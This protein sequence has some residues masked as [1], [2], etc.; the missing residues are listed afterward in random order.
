MEMTFAMIKPNA[1]RAG[2]TAKV[3]E[4]YESARLAICGMKLK[5]MSLEDVQGFYAEHVEKPFFAELAEFM[6]SGPTVLLALGGEDAVAK[7]RFLNGA[8][9]PEKADPGTIRHDL[10]RSI[11]ENVV[12][13]SDSSESAKREVAF[14]FSDAELYE[15]PIPDF[16]VAK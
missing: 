2:L 15:T 7:V 8:T 12:H 4:R 6:T 3:L 11:T 9:N 16:R 1:V 13:A 5:Q 14:W 10:A